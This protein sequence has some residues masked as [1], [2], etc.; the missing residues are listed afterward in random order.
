LNHSVFFYEIKNETGAAIN[1]AKK[2]FD[3]AIADLEN[4]DDEEQ[5]DSAT[6]MQLL[7]DNITLWTKDL[8]DVIVFM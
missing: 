8:G 5:I 3:E 6:I 1:I 4:L 7:R 2:A